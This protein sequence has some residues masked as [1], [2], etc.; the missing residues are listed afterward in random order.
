MRSFA[1]LTLRFEVALHKQGFERRLIM[2]NLEPHISEGRKS[3]PH[4]SR[5]FAKKLLVVSISSN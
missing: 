4:T 3:R 5:P 2:K 1:L